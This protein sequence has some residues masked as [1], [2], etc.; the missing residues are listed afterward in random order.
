MIGRSRII[1]IF[2]VFYANYWQESTF[3]EVLAGN[4]FNEC[5]GERT[6]IHRVGDFCT[7]NMN[8]G[9]CV[10]L[11]TC[12]TENTLM[13]VPSCNITIEMLMEKRKPAFECFN[14]G[15]YDFT[16]RRC[17]C[18]YPYIIGRQCETADP[19][20][21]VNCGMNGHCSEGHCICDFMFGGENCQIKQDCGPPNKR[22]T[23]SR[24]ICETGYE[25][26]DCDT[27]M[28]GLVCIPSKPDSRIY[29]P[30]VITNDHA[31]E[32]LLSS[33]P[34]DGY[35]I[36]PFV[37]TSKIHNCGCEIEVGQSPSQ[38]LALVALTENFAPL[39]KRFEE[40]HGAIPRH[41]DYIH[42][43]YEKHYIR[44]EDCDVSSF[45]IFMIVLTIV[46]FLLIIFFCF[47]AFKKPQ[48]YVKSHNDPPVQTRTT[49]T[50]RGTPD[51]SKPIPM[52]YF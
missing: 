16:S 14:G 29:V 9:C 23:G 26:N 13:C 43:L 10:G 49:N 27:C 25:G 5:G 45:S 3:R 17:Q 32:F 44:T 1:L 30:T 28:K 39:Q 48:V 46:I 50:A 34:P 18:Q 22:W 8:N 6:L 19:C 24:C 37:P 52:N 40:D 42:H 41:S 21:N 36:K 2:L 11:L 51:Y 47:Y 15:I 33:S 12:Q 7:A 20:M 4:V 31:R 35:I 38:S